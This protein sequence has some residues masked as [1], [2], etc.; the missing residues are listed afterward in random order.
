MARINNYIKDDIVEPTDIVIGTEQSTGKTKNYSIDSIRNFFVTETNVGGIIFKKGSHLVSG[1]FTANSNYFSGVTEFKFNKT[2][3]QG[4]SVIPIFNTL[5]TNLV[6]NRFTIN[7]EDATKQNRFILAKILNITDS[8]TFFIITLDTIKNVGNGELVMGNNFSVEV[9]LY[10]E[11]IDG[12]KITNVTS[13]KVGN[14]TTVTVNGDFDNAPLV[15]EILDGDA[16]TGVDWSNLLNIPISFPPSNH[17]HPISDI[18][19]LQTALD[20]K[21]DENTPILGATKTKITYDSKGLVTAGAD[22]LIADIADFPEIYEEYITDVVAK[23]LLDNTSNWNID[24]VYTGT[25][26]TGTF[27]GQRHYNSAYHFSAVDNNLWIR[28]PRV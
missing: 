13:N 25:V 1:E 5:K 12:T 21:V 11:A 3:T 4:D 24:G 17:L 26:I 19:N 7:V 27:K 28:T 10:T 20:G 2:N 18:T 8:D 16:T 6:N 14:K 15:F 9:G 23:G 22:I